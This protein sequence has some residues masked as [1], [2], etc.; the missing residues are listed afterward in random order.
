M[1]TAIIAGLP[2]D[3]DRRV[4]AAL[5]ET[6]PF[7]G[8]WE[9]I[10]MRSNNRMPGLAPSQLDDAR[11]TA[12]ANG[13]HLLILRGRGKHEE[14]LVVTEMTPYFRMRWLEHTLLKLIPHSM[15]QFFEEISRFLSEELEWIDTVKP[16]DESCCLLLPECAFS[17]EADVRHL[18]N[19]AT[20]AGVERIRLA[21]RASERFRF[22]HWLPHKNGSRGWIDRYDR[23]FDHRGARHG[24]APFPRAWKFS[25]Q[26]VPGFHFDVT[27]RISREFQVHASNGRRHDAPGLG[28]INIDPHGH[29][30]I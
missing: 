13:A 7:P 9:V 8:A 1:P 17:A 11:R 10:W 26:V 22:K 23:V 19:A 5:K 18:W 24:I 28:H 27:S 2:P 4:Q 6:S 21:A 25:Y 12:S 16:H 29:V 30:R 20:E 3:T 14:N 15:D